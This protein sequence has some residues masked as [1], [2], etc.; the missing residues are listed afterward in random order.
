MDDI[1]SFDCINLVLRADATAELVCLLPFLEREESAPHEA[2][3][4]NNRAYSG[5]LRLFPF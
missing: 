1:Y 2:F 4:E 3:Y 5:P